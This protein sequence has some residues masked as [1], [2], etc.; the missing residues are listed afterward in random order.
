MSVIWSPEPSTSAAVGSVFLIT[1][2]NGD[3]S[4]VLLSAISF[5]ENGIVVGFSVLNNDEAFVVAVNLGD[6]SVVCSPELS[7]TV[8]WE[9]ELVSVDL[10]SVSVSLVNA[11]FLLSVDTDGFSV[12]YSDEAAV[13]AGCEVTLILV[14][15]DSVSV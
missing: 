12:L 11:V 1:G 8:A 3:T 5:S 4:V 15:S 6:C 10:D 9:I 2:D 7:S 14:S 13:A